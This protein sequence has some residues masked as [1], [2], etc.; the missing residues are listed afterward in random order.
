MKTADA[1]MAIQ[2]KH[3]CSSASWPVEFKN[4]KEHSLQGPA[5]HKTTDYC[6]NSPSVLYLYHSILNSIHC[7][8]HGPHLPSHKSHMVPRP[9]KPPQLAQVSCPLQQFA[10]R[11]SWTSHRRAAAPRPKKTKAPGLKRSLW[12]DTRRLISRDLFQSTGWLISEEKGQRKQLHTPY[13]PYLMLISTNI[14][15]QI[16]AVMPPASLRNRPRPQTAPNGPCFDDVSN[17]NHK[18]IIL[19]SV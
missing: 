3:M 14:D 5:C 18:R 11:V 19:P 10:G 13:W 16:S 7:A 9:L 8:H 4:K 2:I 1:F 15:L 12:R 6:T 17:I